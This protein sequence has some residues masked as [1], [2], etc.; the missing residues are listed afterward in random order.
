MKEAGAKYPER[1]PINP[2]W[3]ILPQEHEHAP[4]GRPPFDILYIPETPRIIRLEDIFFNPEGR[5]RK[6]D[7]SILE[8]QILDIIAKRQQTI[9]DFN[10]ALEKELA[11]QGKSSEEIAV[12][13]KSF[14]MDN[15]QDYT[16]MILA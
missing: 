1:L 8:G 3:S 9:E 11:A 10:T 16:P 15:W 14:L 5:L 12:R 7:N 6:T 13:R 4:M 2:Q